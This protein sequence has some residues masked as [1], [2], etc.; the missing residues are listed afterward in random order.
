MG[1][2]I[3]IPT[4]LRAFTADKEAV[5]V[6]G[7]TVGEGLRHLIHQYP[8]MEKV[9]LTSEGRLHSYVGVFV[10]GEDI[11]P[12]DLAKPIKEDDKLTLLYLIGG[13]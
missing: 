8:D 12:E 3:D 10:N 11:Y 6:N 7:S 5:E 1:V 2:K 9:V 4:Y 13:G